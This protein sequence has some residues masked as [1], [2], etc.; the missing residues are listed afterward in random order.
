MKYAIFFKLLGAIDGKHITII[1]PQHS[2]S[3]YF[4][5]KRYF[6]IVLLA[7]CDA[8]YNFIDIDVECYGQAAALTINEYSEWAEK[9]KQLILFVIPWVM[10]S[11]SYSLGCNN[12]FAGHVLFSVL[13]V[14]YVLT[15]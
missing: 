7:I 4:N 14:H 1:K 6:S 10:S 15:N 9:I 5:Y 13:R 12:S 11:C 3:E 8:N 2:G